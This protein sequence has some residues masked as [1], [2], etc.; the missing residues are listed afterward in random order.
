MQGALYNP[1]IR[2]LLRSPF[3]RLLSR[4]TLL[5]T[6]R[7]RRSGTVYCTP[8]NYLRDGNDLLLVTQRQHRWWH[9]LRGGAPVTICLQGRD[10]T[11]L[12][13][14]L[15]GE[16]ALADGGLLTLVRTVPQYRKYWKLELDSQG[17]LVQPDALRRIADENVLIRLSM[18]QLSAA[19]AT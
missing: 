6:Y 18:V 13:T 17:R 3:Q 9:N 5:L 19:S 4:S 2:W 1:L 14:A 12:A 11:A 7:G 10:Y 8:V 16:A 15:V